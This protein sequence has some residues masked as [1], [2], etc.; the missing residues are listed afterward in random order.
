MGSVVILDYGSGNLRSVAKAIQHAAAGDWSVQISGERADI[1]AADRVIFPGQGAMGQCMRNLEGKS[2]PSLLQE[3]ILNKPFLGIC[4]GLQT[5]LDFSEEDGGMAGLGVIPGKV[6]EFPAGRRDEN[7]A[8]Y[9]IPHMGWN[10]V[11]QTAPHPLWRNIQPDEWFYFV[12][13]YYAQPQQE[14]DC[15]GVANYIVDFAAAVARDNLFAT[16]FHP[17]KSQAG[18]LTLLKNFLEWRP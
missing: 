13:S 12:H 4:L 15:A 3:C 6:L 9:K 2:F 18:G 7:G 10:Q 5:L 1:V 14:A 16:Q 8:P 17:E 11:R